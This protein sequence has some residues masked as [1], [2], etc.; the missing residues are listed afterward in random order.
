MIREKD[1]IHF[2]GGEVMDSRSAAG[3]VN[4]VSHA[5]M[6]H[7][8][9]GSGKVVCSDLTGKLAE[10][11]TGKRLDRVSREDI[12]LVPSGHILGS[13]AALFND[14]RYLYTGD[15][16]P[17]SRAYL[18]GFEPPSA[19]VL[20][21]EATYGIP[22]YR[23]PEQEELESRIVEWME[24]TRAPLFLFAYSL[25]KAQKIQHLAKKTSR[26]LYV[27]EKVL[28]MNHVIEENTGLEFEAERYGGEMP[29]NGIFVG[30][31]GLA[32]NDSFRERV[33]NSAGITAGFTGW[34]VGSRSR[35]YDRTFPYSDHAD[36]DELVSVVED[37][38]PEKVYTFH[39]FDEAFAS[40]L[41]RQG[42]NARALK[43]NQ[44]SL[45][46]F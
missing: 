9:T 41:R 2:P 37:V 30:P 13:R 39:G 14:G 38:A 17:R 31:T 5:H 36:F 46:D 21:M 7:V 18:D 24:D 42:Y 19:E 16:S 23:F 40:Y 27:H 20:V 35:R 28:E 26:P 45:A 8:H 44:A 15:F 12:E 10:A 4:F 33:D 6:D 11:R 25:G 32:R 43:Q 29:D 22:A 34:A 1:G 3:K